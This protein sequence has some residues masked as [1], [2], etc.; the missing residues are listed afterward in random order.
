MDHDLVVLGYFYN[1]PRDNMGKDGVSDPLRLNSGTGRWF[2]A[3]TRF[4]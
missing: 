2:E 4:R 3:T 1:D